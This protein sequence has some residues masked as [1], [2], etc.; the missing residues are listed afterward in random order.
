MPKPLSMISMMKFSAEAEAWIFMD[1]PLSVYLAA[2]DNKFEIALYNSPLSPLMRTCGSQST[3]Y[4]CFF[5]VKTCCVSPVISINSDN[6]STSSLC[7]VGASVSSEDSINKSFIRFFM[8]ID[9]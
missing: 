2:L 8:R 4:S 6:K 1:P 5:F 3:A 7:P 9:D